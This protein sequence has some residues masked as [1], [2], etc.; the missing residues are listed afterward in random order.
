MSKKTYADLK[1]KLEAVPG[2]KEFMSRERI[3]LVKRVLGLRKEMDVTRHEVLDGLA[4]RGSSVT[5][6][7]L[8]GIEF[9]E[10]SIGLEYFEEVINYLEGLRDE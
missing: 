6:E 5:Y 2:A 4:E 7:M 10:E 3:G 8:S 9:A 1:A